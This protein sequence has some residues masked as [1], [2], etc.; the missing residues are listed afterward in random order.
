MHSMALRRKWR[1]TGIVLAALTLIAAFVAAPAL[2]IRAQD[3]ALF[4]TAHERQRIDSRLA[5]EVE[6]I[7]L[8]QAIHTLYGSEGGSWYF[9]S[10]SKLTEVVWQ[11]SE[12]SIDLFDAQIDAMLEAGVF[13]QTIADQLKSAPPSFEGWPE[14]QLAVDQSSGRLLKQPYRRNPDKDGH[15]YW[16]P[17]VDG[18]RDD[19]GVIWI[20]RAYLFEGEEDE[21][22]GPRV[23]SS[24]ILL[25]PKTGKALT[26][27]NQTP[28]LEFTLA[29]RKEAAERYISYLGLD[30][31]DDW[32]WVGGNYSSEKALLYVYVGEEET[33]PL[34]LNIY[35]NPSLAESTELQEKSALP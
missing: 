18:R 11:S 35:P 27:L 8:V 16:Y 28:F 25:E 31:I 4:H 33:G 10:S 22:L 13:S 9:N 32:H 34:Y 29:Q 3:H 30:I 6:N 23:D 7:Y 17:A 24:E 5:P 19:R 2:L 20:Q 1:N 26:L 12:E 15:F 14:N 21:E